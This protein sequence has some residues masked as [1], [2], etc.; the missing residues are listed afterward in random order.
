MPGARGVTTDEL[1]LLVALIH[2]VAL[3]F[4]IWVAVAAYR[5]H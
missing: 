2:S 3:L 5:R 4:V 1:L